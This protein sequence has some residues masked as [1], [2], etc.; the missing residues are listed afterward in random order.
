KGAPLDRVP[1]GVWRVPALC[2][3]GLVFLFSVG[4]P[5]LTLLG[6]SF[7]RQW[8]TVLESG[9][10]TLR[11]YSYA[12]FEF[13]LTQQAILNSLGLAAGAATLAMILG[14]LIAYLDL[15]TRFVGRRVLDY[16]SLVP[17]GLPGI[18]LSVGFIQ[19]W[20]RPPLVLYGT[21][22]ILL[23][24]Y[25]ARYIPFAVR[26]ANTSLRQ[27]DPALE[28]AARITG[29]PW[30]T[31]LVAVTI[32]LIK[33]GMLSG[34]LLIFVPALRELSASILL[35]TSGTETISVAIFQLYEEGYFES[36]CALA[37]VTLVVSLT[38]LAIA[39]KVAGPSAWEL[40]SKQARG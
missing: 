10:L 12:L 38:V 6:V 1:L 28:E 8:A 2:L 35:F 13:S 30:L 37:V 33:R 34:W 9:S 3:C 32:P 22:W 14:T 19:A 31:S 5:Y 18:V 39:R 7:S 23:V 24:A 20:I 16:L 15:R 29:A 11:N 4:L 26:S 21:I 27:L 25:M 17:L 40:S 36:V